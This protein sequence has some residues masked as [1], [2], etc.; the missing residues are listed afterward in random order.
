MKLAQIL[1]LIAI[2]FL[3]ANLDSKLN[4]IF[5]ELWYVGPI[6]AH[7]IVHSYYNAVSYN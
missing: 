3:H 5:G 2:P 7:I 1:F 4:S 6:I